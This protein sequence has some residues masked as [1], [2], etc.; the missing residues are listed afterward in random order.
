MKQDFFHHAFKILK[1]RCIGC[2]HCMRSC[3][4]DAIR[5]RNGKATVLPDRCID[6]GKCVQACP[7][8]AIVVDQDDFDQIFEYTYRVALIPAVLVGQFPDNITEEDILNAL[9]DL[10][11]THVC[12]VENAV[13]LLSGHIDQYILEHGAETKPLISSFCPAVIRLIQVK[14]PGLINNIIP[15]KPPL[16]IAASY[17]EKSLLDQGFS[18]DKIGIF[19]ITPCAAKIAS[20][21]SPVEGI[22]SPIQGVININLIYNKIY[23]KIKQRE[24]LPREGLHIQPLTPEEMLWSLTY[25]ECSNRA[26]RCLAID[27]IHNVIAFLERIENEEITDVDFLELRALS[28]IHI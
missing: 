11:F 25:G 14:F 27:G 3:P 4:T 7:V 8:S 9:F 19:Y 26:G 2:T 10:G 13:G 12:E 22:D 24:V 28:L 23:R 20:V 5:I 21:K 15:L 6:C 1:E 18:R 17:V 16:D